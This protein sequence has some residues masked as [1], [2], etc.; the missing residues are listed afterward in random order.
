[1]PF[2]SF[3]NGIFRWVGFTLFLQPMVVYKNLKTSVFAIYEIVKA[4]PDAIK[5]I[6]DLKLDEFKKLIELVLIGIDKVELDT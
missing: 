5:E 3:K 1:M 2:I 6:A 4:M